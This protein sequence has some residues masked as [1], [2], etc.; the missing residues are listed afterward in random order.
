MCRRGRC[1]LEDDVKIEPYVVADTTLGV[2]I[3]LAERDGTL[4]EKGVV[5][6]AVA[7]GHIRL[8]VTNDGQGVKISSDEGWLMVTPRASNALR[9]EIAK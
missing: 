8:Q 3:A 1:L 4:V 9:L 2:D 6:L 7:G 5:R